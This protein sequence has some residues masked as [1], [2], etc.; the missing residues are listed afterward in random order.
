[1]AQIVDADLGQPCL[2]ESLVELP[3]LGVWVERFTSSDT[4]DVS[5][6]EVRVE[7]IKR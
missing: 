7:N 3:R 2:V 4:F 1:M 5:T 6:I